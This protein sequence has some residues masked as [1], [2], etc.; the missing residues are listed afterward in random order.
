MFD[1][2]EAWLRV[3]VDPR[4]YVH[5]VGVQVSTLQKNLGI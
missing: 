5:D 4:L 2:V 1:E 3:D